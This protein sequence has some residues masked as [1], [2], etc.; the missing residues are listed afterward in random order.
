[1]GYF[2]LTF[3]RICISGFGET[4]GQFILENWCRFLDDCE[5]P[6]GKSKTDPNRLLEIFNSINPSINFTMETSDK[7]LPFLD[8]LIKRNDGKIWID[9]YFKPTGTLGRLPFSSRHPNH[10]TETIPF[11]LA[12][13]ICTIVE[14]QQQKLRHLSELKENLKNMTTRQYNN[15]WYQ[16]SLKNSSK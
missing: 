11:T 14:N 1:M 4:P 9:I 6:L 13:R 2:E 3:Y 7:E 16:E 8:I 5:T 10:C 12:Q 15:N